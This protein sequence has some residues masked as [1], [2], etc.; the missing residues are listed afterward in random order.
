M[1]FH[2][3]LHKFH[4]GCVIFPRCCFRW[5]PF[6]VFV[7]VWLHTIFFLTTVLQICAY[8]E[9]QCPP[10]YVKCSYAIPSIQGP[11]HHVSGCKT[12]PTFLHSD[13]WK[14][15]CYTACHLPCNICKFAHKTQ[16]IA[17]GQFFFVRNLVS[18]VC[19]F[20]PFV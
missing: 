19:R 10:D 11:A 13:L 6:L 16:H 1:S 20:M 2:V 3:V 18:F 12:E 5:K 17:H 4:E 15:V 8:Y 9:P 14:R 7:H